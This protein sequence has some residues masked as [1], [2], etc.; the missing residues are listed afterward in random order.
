[1][2]TL[3]EAFVQTLLPTLCMRCRESLPLAGSRAGVCGSCWGQ[4]LPHAGR[5]CPVCGDPGVEGEGACL[6]CRT[7]PPPWR[8]ATSY[9]PY[10]G[11]LRELV[12]DLKHHRRDELAAPLAALQLQA[13]RRAGWPRPGLVVPVPMPWLRKLHRGFNHAD[14]LARSLARSIGA[15]VANPLGRRGLRRQV[16]RGRR[17]RLTVG[18]SAFTARTAVSGRIVLVDDVFTT[19]ATAAACTLSLRAAGAEEVFVLTLARTPLSGRIP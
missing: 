5:L 18:P 13:W 3:A 6:A 15:P 12:L 19:G 7:S 4:V 10:Q 11:L 14:L 2:A 16:G 17:A 8:A 1:M 9:G